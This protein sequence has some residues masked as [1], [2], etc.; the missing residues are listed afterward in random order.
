M[1]YKDGVL[2]VSDFQ[3]GQADSPYLGFDTMRAV[4]ITATPGVAKISYKTEEMAGF[5]PTGIPTA[6]CSDDYGNFY[7]LVADTGSGNAELYKN[8]TSVSSLSG[9]GWDMIFYKGYILVR[10]GSSLSAYET[11]VAS[12]TL[13]Q[14]WKSG[15]TQTYYGKMLVSKNDGNV[16]IADGTNVKRISA[17]VAG[18]AGVAPT[19]TADTAIALITGYAATTIAELGSRLMVGTQT[20]NSIWVTRYASQ[21]ATI[22][23][24]RIGVS[25]TNF[26]NPVQISNANCIQQII[27]SNNLMYITAGMKGNI[28]VSDGTSYR[29][30]KTIPYAVKDE[31]GLGLLLYPNAI[32]I[33]SNGN[34]LIGTSSYTNGYTG[35]VTQHGVWE[36]NLATGKYETNLRYIM[37]NGEFTGNTQ[38][39]IGFVFQTNADQVIFGWGYGSDYGIDKTSQYKYSGYTATIE[40]QLYIVGNKLS[41]KT[42]ENVEILVGQPLTLGQ[43]I[44]L[45]YRLSTFGDYTPIGTWDYSTVGSV[46]SIRDKALITN[47]QS[48][49]IKIEMTT[50]SST[51]GIT[52]NQ[53]IELLSVT[54]W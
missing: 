32:T 52:P 20:T 47:A 51:S 28:Y 34:L 49:Q 7:Q 27:V 5:T 4:D 25:A 9:Y 42:F 54:F 10:H 30:V 40:T 46:I 53:N 24:Y 14:A 29:Q 12:P 37:S 13:F 39:S 8:G 21:G 15:Y 17:F 3:K 50:Q 43:G 1:A 22:F 16:Y 6:Y 38:I 11:T 36:V 2:T 48:L 45:S 41:P 19:A 31:S 26:D 18:S 23:P 35:D 33:A 44:R